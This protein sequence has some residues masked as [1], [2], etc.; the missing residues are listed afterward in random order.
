MQDFFLQLGHALK[1]SKPCNSG[2]IIYEGNSVSKAGAFH[3]VTVTPAFWGEGP[4]ANMH[5]EPE[6]VIDKWLFQ[7]DDSK[8][9]CEKLLFYQ[10]SIL[11]W[12]FGVPGNT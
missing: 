9:L 2:C 11:N 1:L 4:D 7:L 12:M 10:T 3:S 6:T 8:S 5:L